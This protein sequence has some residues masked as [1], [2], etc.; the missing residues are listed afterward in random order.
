M[1][2]VRYIPHLPD[3]D[4]AKEILERLRRE[5]LPIAKA[6]NWTVTH[7]S[8]MC[9]CGDGMDHQ[10]HNPGVGGSSAGSKRGRG[11]GRRGTRRMADNVG[12]YNISGHAGPGICRIHIRLRQPTDHSILHGY[13]NAAGTMSHELAHCAHKNHSAAFYKLMD[14]VQEQHSRYLA[15]G[16][17]VDKDGF[18][19]GGE[20]HTLG[21]RRSTGGRGGFAGMT[22]IAAAAETGSTAGGVDLR[23]AVR[24]AAEQRS[25]WPERMGARRLGG[26][27]ADS[28]GG[29]GMDPS[30]PPRDA[31]RIAA[32]RRRFLDSQWC[33]PCDEVIEIEGESSSENDGGEE[34]EYC[35]TTRSSKE[36]APQGVG[37]RSSGATEKNVRKKKARAS[38]IASSTQKKYGANANGNVDDGV[39]VDL[40]RSQ[41]P[42]AEVASASAS[43]NDKNDGS[44]LQ[45]EW[46]CTVCTW[47]NDAIAVTCRTCNS[48]RSRGCSGSDLKPNGDDFTDWACAACTLRNRSDALACSAC[49]KER[50]DNGKRAAASAERKILRDEAIDAVKE[51]EVG[52]SEVTFGGFNIYG[53]SKRKTGTLPHLT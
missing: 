7:I 3:A 22:G 42:V 13:E 32:E 37:D 41:S 19:M 51:N 50:W 31:A 10:H 33:L 38:T 29:G 5:F 45:R 49:G 36:D 20:A 39:I 11:A 28:G 44:S 40:T 35:T 21:G 52:Q 30:L 6:R 2:E 43:M 17:V 23:D 8:E 15:C 18:P 27:A 1:M 4:R 14:D 26:G 34:E 25:K 48:V 24:R 47:I 12:G 9:C 16:I 53:S 46:M